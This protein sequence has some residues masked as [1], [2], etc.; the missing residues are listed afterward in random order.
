MKLLVG[1][2]MVL[3]FMVISTAASMI[4]IDSLDA[5]INLYGESIV[6]DV[7][8]IWNIRCDLVSAQR[9]LLRA[10]LANNMANES[11]IKIDHASNEQAIAIEQVKQGLTQVSAVVQTN[12][13]TAEENS[14]TSEE[15]S[16]QA[17]TLREEVR[18][19]KLDFYCHDDETVKPISL[20]G[21]AAKAKRKDIG[22]SA[23]MLKYGM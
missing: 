2:R 11:I 17:S 18:K 9:Y 10:I 4:N 16:A 7:D 1:F 21:D 6:P 23:F 8:N 14:A 15:M 19:F 3:V 5:H 20:L 22:N 12:A 13:A